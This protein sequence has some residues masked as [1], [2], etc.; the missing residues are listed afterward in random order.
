MKIMK[1][2]IIDNINDAIER[3][4]N[5]DALTWLDE[6]PLT[7]RE[8]GE[9]YQEVANLLKEQG[10]RYGD[11][12][13]ILSENSPNWGISYLAIVSMGAIVVP[14]LTEFQEN[15][16]HHILR[17]AEAKAIFVSNKLFPKFETLFGAGKEIIAIDIED[18]HIINPSSSLSKIKAMLLDRRDSMLDKTGIIG[19]I[20]GFKN[21]QI[22]ENHTAVIIYTSGTTGQSKGVMLT[23]KNL[24]TN[25]Q[26]C[27]KVQP[28]DH[29]DRLISILPLPH[30]YE[31]TL[32]FLFPL[33]HNST[34]TYL[35]RPPTASVLLPALTKV[36]PTIMLTVPLIMEKIFKNK[37]HPTL[38]SS[39]IMRFLYSIPTIRKVL[40]KVAGKKLYKSFGGHLKFYGIGGAKIASDVEKFLQDSN[41]PYSIGYG[42][43]ETSPLV[44]GAPPATTRFRSTGPVVFNLQYKL[45]NT[46]PKTGEGEIVVKGDSVMKGYYKDENATKAVFTEDGYFKT[47]DLGQLKR[48]YLYIKGRLKNVIVGSSGENI[49]PEEI[50]S[51][52]NENEF[53]VES[54]VLE[55]DSKLLAKIHLN[56]DY[57]DQIHGAH[58]LSEAKLKREITK[59]LDTIK[60]DVNSKVS[61]F[62]KISKVQ[63]QIEP[64]EKTPTMKVKRYLYR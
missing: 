57:I 25:I 46:N 16:I 32:G 28:M 53:V 49:Y 40:H 41:F 20:A 15:E 21:K 56:Y 12:V 11:K 6:S 9:K 51:I 24:I 38:T 5:H 30:T 48:G 10:I 45:I 44:A 63:E 60:S 42:L 47:G 64:F 33:M 18:Y 3:F 23:H 19:E 36:Q 54:L 59:I 43:T 55:Q 13:A 62:S 50:E 2:T 39:T 35:R 31:C 22:D 8:L 29:K 34:I 17:H 61:S 58:S 26:A 14:I 7:Y 52:I 27:Y 1:K 4:P 37:I